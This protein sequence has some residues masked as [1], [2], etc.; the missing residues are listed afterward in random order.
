M[1]VNIEGLDA[2]AEQASSYFSPF[3]SPLPGMRRLSPGDIVWLHRYGD[4][5]RDLTTVKDPSGARTFVLDLS[6]VDPAIALMVESRIGSVDPA[7]REGRNIIELP[8]MEEDL[9]GIIRLAITGTLRSGTWDLQT[10]YVAAADEIHASEPDLTVDEFLA[11]SP[12]ARSGQST[13]K[14]RTAF[15][16]SPVVC[17]VGET[18]DDHALALLCDRLFQ[19]AA[20]VPTHLVADDAPL[21]T[22]VR[23]ALY[24]LRNAV[25]APDRPVLITS[26]SEPAALVGSLATSLNDMFGIYTEDGKPIHGSSKF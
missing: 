7:D 4:S 23:V 16:E 25:G 22:A 8:V 3:K 2:L 13:I 10:R 12:F 11:D 26:I 18:A 14:I 6:Q 20:W 21:R 1:P 17:V 9:P 19:H 5:Q 15:P 24:S